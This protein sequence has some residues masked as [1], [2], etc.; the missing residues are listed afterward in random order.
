[1]P[2][3]LSNP[4]GETYQCFMICCRTLMPVAHVR[5]PKFDWHEPQF[6]PQSAAFLKA[7]LWA[8]MHCLEGI[9]RENLKRLWNFGSA[10]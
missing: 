10:Q 1:M 6:A 5:W 8:C 9:I 7:S 2:S 4:T 3:S